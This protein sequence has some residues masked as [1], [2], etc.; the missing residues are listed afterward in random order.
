MS[1]PC[2]CVTFSIHGKNF[3]GSSVPSAERH[4]VHA[5]RLDVVVMVVMMIVV[6]VMTVVIV[7]VVIVIVV[8]IVAVEELRIERQD[9]VEIEGAAVEHLV[10]RNGAALGPV[11]DRVRVD[12]ADARARRRRAPPARRDRSC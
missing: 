11:D 7:M 9:A 10:E 8:V 3:F 12:G 2:S 1:G 4:A 6:M 5:R